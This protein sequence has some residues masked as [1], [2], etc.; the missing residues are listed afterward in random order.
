MTISPSGKILAV[1]VGTGVRFF[2]F[3]GAEPITE[4]T[5]I[6][7][8]SGYISSMQ[9]DNSNHLYAISYQSQE[10]YVLTVT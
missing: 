1:S 9:W 2:H 10:L 8:T 7:G 5:G 4:F 3:N 6:I